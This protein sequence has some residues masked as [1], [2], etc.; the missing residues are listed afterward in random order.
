MAT[1]PAEDVDDRDRASRTLATF[2]RD[3]RLT[4]LPARWSRKLI[5]LRHIAEETFRPGTDYTERAVN[6]KL[7]VWCEGGQVD[8]ATLR[9]CLVDLHHL[10]RSDGVYW[11]PVERA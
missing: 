2:V 1:E 3:G 4:R 8:H 5:V 7:R 6:E 11:R 10:R 9:R